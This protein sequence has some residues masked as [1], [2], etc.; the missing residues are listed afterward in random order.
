MCIIFK[1]H[2]DHKYTKKDTFVRTRTLFVIDP[3]ETDIFV[4][5]VHVSRAVLKHGD[6]LTVPFLIRF[7]VI[8]LLL[9]HR[10]PIGVPIYILC[11]LVVG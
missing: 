9:T 7:L 11:A 6:Q 3:V 10:L 8:F 1:E 4:P 5:R 2:A